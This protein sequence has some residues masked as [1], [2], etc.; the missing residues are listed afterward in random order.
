MNILGISCF[1]H[2]SAAALII[3]GTVVAGALEERFTRKKHDNSFPTKAINYCLTSQQL[4]TEDLDL[5]VFYEKPVI[6]FERI[7]KQYVEYYPKT[8]QTF[9]D[10]FAKVKTT[11]LQLEKLIRDTLN[12]QGKIWYLPHHLSHAAFAYYS[13]PFS[14]ATILTID[15]VG[16]KATTSVSTA[17]DSEIILHKEIHFPHSIGLLY[18]AGTAFLGFKV[19]NDEY[20]V[21]GLAAY[22]DPSRYIHKLRQLIK[23]YPDG[24]FELDVNY[25]AFMWGN[26]MAS[27]KF[28]QLVQLKPRKPESKLTRQHKDL[29][30]AFQLLTEEVTGNLIDQILIEYPNKQLC[31]GGGVFLNSVMNGKLEMHRKEKIFVP[32]DPGDGGSAI[33]CALYAYHQLK[34]QKYTPTKIS[35]YLGPKYSHTEV[36]KALKSKPK[37]SYQQI[38]SKQAL[39]QKATQYLI[40]NQVVGWFQNR[41]EWGPRALGNRSILASATDGKMKDILNLKV[42]KREDFRPFAPTIMSEQVKNYF[43]L[44]N[45]TLTQS[46]KFMSLVLPVSNQAVTQTPAI[47]HVNGTG[48][49]QQ[50]SRSDNPLYYD[51]ITNYYQQTGIALIINTSFNVRG[52][53]IVCTPENAID[54]Y[55]N[56]DIDVLIIENYLVTK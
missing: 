17:K 6:K 1:Y 30:A 20:K 23:Q 44:T 10:T 19:N 3:D 42:K 15:G 21:M 9:L 56:T 38:Q 55:L 32:F 49:L 22:G 31:L 14:Q 43:K 27:D 24:S 46:A 40:N 48:R 41:M 33:G 2:D 4:T 18:S 13:S 16:E 7:M 47:V 52:E 53:P 34:H 50:L 36:L 11:N 51:L 45:P 25:F 5:V 54:C 28:A 29:A 37:L 35:P 39:L 12:Y 26:S 8:H